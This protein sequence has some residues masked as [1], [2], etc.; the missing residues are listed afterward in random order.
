VK[1]GAQVYGCMVGENV[2]ARTV[3]GAHE[4]ERM[5]LGGRRRQGDGGRV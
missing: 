4:M 2:V 3:R 1:E 5:V